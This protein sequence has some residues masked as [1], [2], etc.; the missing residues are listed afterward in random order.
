MNDNIESYFAKSANNFFQKYK[1]SDDEQIQVRKRLRDL[2]DG[3]K[4]GNFTYD[5]LINGFNNTVGITNGTGF[6]DWGYAAAIAA[7]A[8]NSMPT[9]TPA[10]EETPKLEDFDVTKIGA[11]LKRQIFGTDTISDYS[12]FQRSPNNQVPLIKNSLQDIR[13]RFDDIFS[14]YK[15]VNPKRKKEYLKN[16]DAA[17]AALNDNNITEDEYL[18]LSRATG[19]SD[20][21]NWFRTGSLNSDQSA[22]QNTEQENTTNTSQQVSEQ[23]PMRTSPIEGQLALSS[24]IKDNPEDIKFFA[25]YFTKTPVDLIYDYLNQ[26]L[27]GVSITNYFIPYKGEKF[28]NLI[29]NQQLVKLMLSELGNRKI[30]KVGNDG[31]YYL[32][33][34]LAGTNAIW[35]DPNLNGGSLIFKNKKYISTNKEGGILKFLGG[36]VSNVFYNDK[37]N[38]T[39]IIYNS[40]AYKNAIRGITLD[41]YQAA[42]DLQ[43]R[44]YT[45]HINTG[46]NQ[47]KLNENNLVRQ[48]QVDF[49]NMYPSINTSSIEGAITNGIIGRAGTTGDNS[50]G[51]YA[52]GYAGAM[53]NLRHLGTKDDEDKLEEL[54]NIL[55]PNKLIAFVNPETNMINFKPLEEN[56]AT[57]PASKTPETPGDKENPED[58]ENPSDKPIE[59]VDQVIGRYGELPE[60]E[61]KIDFGWLRNIYP[62]LIA[63]SRLFKTINNNNRTS[64]EIRKSLV[65]LLKDTY[66]LYSPIRGAFGERNQYYSQAHKYLQ[67]ANRLGV[68]DASKLMSAMNEAQL[69]QNEGEIQGDVVDDK[70][71][72]QTA[73]YALKLQ[74]DNVARR[75]AVANENRASILT[76]NQNIAQLEAGRIKSNWD[77]VDKYLQGIEA[78]ARTK[79]A[80]LEED[81]NL[82]AKSIITNEISNWQANMLKPAQD[83]YKAASAKYSDI[84]KWPDYSR[85]LEYVNK[86]SEMARDKQYTKLAKLYNIS[87]TPQYTDYNLTW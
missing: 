7:D 22:E 29:S 78:D 51:N 34:L 33:N 85:Y 50:M 6:D 58:K 8:Y 75:N 1:F 2:A 14:N 9:E 10:T 20:Y 36:G 27:K 16:L 44:Y 52:D 41:N 19:I 81:R 48:Y 13:T 61:N 12:Y 39:D 4:N 82:I 60:E 69:R 46:W 54:N 74:Q 73:E 23:S 43:N 15:I 80:R 57:P 65:P 62:E 67:L 26:F 71:R 3:I 37:Y 70:E 25:K 79:R 45:D 55:K 84:T 66:E 72:N 21:D 40:D 64:K 38:W 30:I 68:S 5:Q 63:T 53:T 11:E 42:N 24:S 28:K 47:N 77:A 87:Y 86:V 31:T 18:T 49:N 59:R 56:P 83:A 17:I 32:P 76:N 35:Y